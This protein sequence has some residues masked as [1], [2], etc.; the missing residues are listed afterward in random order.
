[1]ST[2]QTIL[3]NPNLFT[4][5]MSYVF[6]I[7]LMIALLAFLKG[8]YTSLISDYSLQA[9]ILLSYL[10]VLSLLAA[11]LTL[12]IFTPKILR[13]KYTISINEK[14][15]IIYK[16]SNSI[17]KEFT[18]ADVS[19]ISEKSQE[20]FFY[21][22][23]N[24]IFSL[25]FEF[26]HD[27]VFFNKL[28][29]DYKIAIQDNGLYTIFKPKDDLFIKMILFIT[30]L[31]LVF[32]FPIILFHSITNISIFLFSIIVLGIFFIFFFTTNYIKINPKN[33]E[34]KTTFKTVIISKS[35][36]QKV[37]FKR[38][39][40][41]NGFY[42]H[43]CQLITKLNKIYSLSKS[44]ISSIDLYCYLTFWTNTVHER[45]LIK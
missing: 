39:K 1:M 19:S 41:I 12:Y 16:K 36:I 23:D 15:V 9:K 34:I 14:N 22:K 7:I 29:N 30:S 40:F 10:Y 13:S 43:E 5:I 26:K 20:F 11:S 28:F 25:P 45:H 24:T 27:D 44:G 42:F 6:V 2:D 8:L 4:K 3:Y 21:L 38:I 33:I 17:F 32:F 18:F 31:L 37:E 35:D